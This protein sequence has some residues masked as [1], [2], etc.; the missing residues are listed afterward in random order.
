MGAASL[1]NSD[2]I[3]TDGGHAEH[4]L[5]TGTRWMPDQSTNSVLSTYIESDNVPFDGI[6]VKHTWDLPTIININARSL[7]AEK[8]D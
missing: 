6:K 3:S 5:V 8:V 4:V 7:N 1:I 2:H